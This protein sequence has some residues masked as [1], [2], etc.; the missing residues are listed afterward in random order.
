MHDLLS[1]RDVA[2]MYSVT[3]ATVLNWIRA[4]KL[5][6]YATPG[7]HYRIS[8]QDLEDFSRAFRLP[9][10]KPGAPPGLRLLFVGA[11]ELLYQQVRRAIRALWPSAQVE[12]ACTEFEI[13]WWLSRLHPTNLVAH[14]ALTPSLLIERC[15]QVVSNG[16]GDTPSLHILPESFNGDVS[17]WLAHE[18][19]AN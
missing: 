19:G 18:I 10:V 16:A 9:A 5:K 15:Q 11:D 2:E 13:G 6:A 17:E 12:Q 3:S 1:T 7:G 14:A 8:R 4:G